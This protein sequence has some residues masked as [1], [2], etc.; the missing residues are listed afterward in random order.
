MVTLYEDQLQIN[1]NVF[2]FFD[3]EGK[4]RHPLFIIRKLNPRTANLL[5]WDEHYAPITDIH[6]LFHDISMFEHR[7]NICL[8]F[9][10]SFY[11]E[12][13]LFK[14]QRL[15]SREDFMS[16]VQ[17]LHAAET[18][19]AHIKFKQVRNTYRAAFVIY[20]YFESILEPMERRVKQ[21]FYN[22]QHNI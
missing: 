22:Q 17:V 8:R 14:H 2:S 10:E 5:Y 3:D 16:V 20:A 21:T 12:E 11:T 6:R 7:N 15:C 18:E 19:Q 4:A 1:I 13:S 9:L